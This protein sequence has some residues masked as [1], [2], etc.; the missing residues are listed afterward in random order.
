MF[1]GIPS[2]CISHRARQPRIII[3]LPVHR[4]VQELSFERLDVRFSHF[5]VSYFRSARRYG[6]VCSIKR[7]G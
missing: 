1:G 5:C 3:A 6:A 4:I 7:G 2:S